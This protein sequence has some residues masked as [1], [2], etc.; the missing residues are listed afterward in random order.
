MVD[1]DLGS[2]LIAQAVV[3]A[4]GHDCRCAAD[5]DAAWELFLAYRPD[6]VVSDRAMPGLDGVQ[7]CRAI[8][9]EAND[10]YTYVILV[11]SLTDPEDIIAGME[12]GADDYLTK[13]L[14]AFDLRTR[15]LAARRVTELHAELSRTRGEL[16]KQARTDP[17]TGLRNRLALREE[18]EWLHATSQRYHRSYCIALCDV[19]HFKLYNDTYGHQAGDQALRAVAAVLIAQTRDVDA[20]YRYG[21]EEFLVVLPE[22]R[23]EGAMIAVERVRRRRK[24][25]DPPRRRRSG[26]RAHPQR[27]VGRLAGAADRH[28]RRAALAGRPG[29]LRRQARRAQHGRAG[30]GCRSRSSPLTGSTKPWAM[31]AA[32]MHC[33][34]CG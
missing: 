5:G 1:D 18:L 23:A 14:S 19:D 22:Q 17:L 29:A 6:V 31:L 2:R 33:A 28:E 3:E 24:A 13:P 4:L 10:A 30:R 7:L 12:A 32:A 8:R 27:R 34:C 25:A 11:T 20:S 21:G 26:R 16:A 15:L 9:D